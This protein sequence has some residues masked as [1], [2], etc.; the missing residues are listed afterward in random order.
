VA[1]S[2]PA[3]PGERLW[4]RRFFSVSVTEAGRPR[5]LVERTRI[6]ISFEKR[7]PEGVVRWKAGC[8]TSGVTVL[9]SIDRLELTDYGV[10]SSMLCAKPY[11]DQDDWF[12]SLMRPGPFWR[13]NDERLTLTSGETVIEF[14]E[15]SEP[16]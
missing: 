3:S 13:L 9:I 7:D 5:P 11:M 8:N 15:T 6:S 2:E 14:E 4:G 1:A 10:S 12:A 16:E